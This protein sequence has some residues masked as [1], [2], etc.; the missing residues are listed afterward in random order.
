MANFPQPNAGR[1]RDQ[2]GKVVG[3]SGKSIDYAS[4]V[5]EQ[6]EPELIKA[7][8]EGR[9]AISTAAILSAESPEQQVSEAP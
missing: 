8:D 3:V 1:A 9:M 6:G 2:V 5:L 7:V 4:R